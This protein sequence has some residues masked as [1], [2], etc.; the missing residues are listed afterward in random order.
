MIETHDKYWNDLSDLVHEAIKKCGE[1]NDHEYDEESVDRYIFESLDSWTSCGDYAL[2][3]LAHT[4]NRNAYFDELGCE[5]IRSSSTSD[6]VG[7]LAFVAIRMDAYGIL[8]D[9][10]NDEH[11][12]N[13]LLGQTECPTC[14]YW[15]ADKAEAAECCEEEEE[16][17][18]A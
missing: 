9:L 12:F 2:S 8:A 11:E 15:H 18:A 7:R 17:G 3:V 4:N 5:P 13:T 1:S 10:R 14:G 16:E 6:V